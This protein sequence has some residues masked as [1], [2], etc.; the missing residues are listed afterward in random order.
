MPEEEGHKKDILKDSHIFETEILMYSKALPEFERILQ[1]AGDNT[2]LYVPCIYLFQE[3]YWALINIHSWNFYL[4]TYNFLI[5]FIYF[6]L[7]V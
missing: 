6:L 3:N 1:E 2:K 7:A 4:Y 5:D